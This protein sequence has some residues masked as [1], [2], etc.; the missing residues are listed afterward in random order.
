MMENKFILCPEGWAVN[1]KHTVTVSPVKTNGSS[2]STGNLVY[3]YMTMANGKEE[4]FK[5][6]IANYTESV[7]ELVHKVNTI[8]SIILRMVN[9]DAEPI[10][11]NAPINLNKEKTNQ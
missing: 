11:I 2:M 7:E 6:P 10:E 5:Y 8:R 1:I 4:Y 9:G 3:F